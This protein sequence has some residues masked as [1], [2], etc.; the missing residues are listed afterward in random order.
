MLSNM[1]IWIDADACPNVVKEI[2]Y[3]ASKR[4]EIPVTLVANSPLRVPLSPL[5]KSVLVEKY[6]DEADFYIQ[7]YASKGDLVI[8]ADIPLASALVEGSGVV[9]MNP[10][11]S[12]YTASSIKEALA[13][14]N[15]MTEL[16]GGGMISGG[17]APLGP[18]DKEKF[19]NAFDREITKLNKN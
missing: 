18:K 4:L 12:V 15:L 10:R 13:M 7:K 9:V 11:G 1:Q 19:A 8:T 16:R 5:I 14:R 17:S 6:F 2:V 3:K